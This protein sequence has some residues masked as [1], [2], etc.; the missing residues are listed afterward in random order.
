MWYDAAFWWGHKQLA[1]MLPY[2][3]NFGVQMLRAVVF[4][5]FQVNALWHFSMCCHTHENLKKKMQLV[6][7]RW[8][9]CITISVGSGR[10]ERNLVEDLCCNS[11]PPAVA[12]V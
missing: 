7:I 6:C 3:H 4:K 12:R 9:D 2:Q 1:A 10:L 8:N 5:A 11:A